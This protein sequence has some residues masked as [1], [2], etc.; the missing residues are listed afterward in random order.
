LL[1]V[2]AEPSSEP[3]AIARKGV[4]D[5][6]PAAAESFTQLRDVWTEV[7]EVGCDGQLA[8]R[9]HEEARGLPV[10]FLDPE[11]LRKRDR[12]IVAGVVEYPQDDGV[13]VVIPQADRFGR[14]GDFVALGLVVS[15]YIRAQC[16]FFTVCPGCFVVCNT[17]C[18]HE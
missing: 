18:G 12:L 14:T 1:I 16:S 11:D 4:L 17:V 6:E 2:D 8:V 15:Q 9:G 10:R 7:G 13:T 5:L 3:G